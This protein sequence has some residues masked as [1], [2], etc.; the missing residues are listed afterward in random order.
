MR[1]PTSEFGLA[2]W[3][4]LLVRVRGDGRT[5]SVQGWRSGGRSDGHYWN[6]EFA[7]EPDEWIEV[8]VPFTEMIHTVMGFSL[9]DSIDPARIGS[10]AFM[11]ADEDERPFALEIDWIK[12][13]RER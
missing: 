7:T 10:L 11:I 2:G 5:Y 3:D 1:S 12:A 13:W 9:G 6:H 4:G 8:R